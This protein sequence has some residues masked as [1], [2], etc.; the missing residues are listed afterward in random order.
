MFVRHNERK[1]ISFLVSL[2]EK[3]QVAERIAFIF[4]ILIRFVISLS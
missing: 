2:D 1:T 4:N 3:L